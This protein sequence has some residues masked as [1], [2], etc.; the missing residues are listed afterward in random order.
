MPNK[1]KETLVG[2]QPTGDLTK[3]GNPNHNSD[4]Q[5]TSKDEVYTKDD[6]KYLDEDGMDFVSFLFEDYDTG[7]IDY[8]LALKSEEVKNLIKIGKEKDKFAKEAMGEEVELDDNWDEGEFAGLD[9]DFDE[10]FNLDGPISGLESE[11]IYEKIKEI[12]EKFIDE[13]TSNTLSLI[14]KEDKVNGLINNILYDENKIKNATDEEIELLFLSEHLKAKE[15]DILNEELELEKETF[16]NIWKD[17]SV[18][19]KDYLDKMDSI[20]SKK[21]YYENEISKIKDLALD[22]DTKEAYTLN[23][24]QSKLDQLNKFEQLG[25]KY[26]KLRDEYFNLKSYE[27][28]KELSEISEKFRNSDNPYSE[29]R[30]N[31]AIWFNSGSKYE[32]AKN[33]T[34]H[35][36]EETMQHF[37]NMSPE[38]KDVLYTYTTGSRRYNEPL[39]HRNYTAGKEYNEDFVPD[40]VN[41]T[42]AIDKCTWKD[43]VWV[44]RF[45]D[46]NSMFLKT[47]GDFKGKDIYALSDDE[48]QALVGSTIEDTGFFSAGAGKGTGWDG[49]GGTPII[50]NTYCPRGTKMAYLNVHGHFSESPENEMLLQRGYSYRI[51]KV[52]KKMNSYGGYEFYVDM[53]VI[54][55]S[56]ENKFSLEELNKIEKQY[57]KPYKNSWQ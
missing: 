34:K 4:G 42:N 7:E 23:Y 46:K 52:E 21:E 35:F 11:E 57:V 26:E 38:E 43:D 19:V 45:V 56:D 14:D 49:S 37:S 5:F 2:G 36:K 44:Q 15:K 53:E 13:E 41:M 24:L 6:F 31:N 17:Q 9:F 48:L 33:A 22:N 50:L 3:S 29:E 39:R 54:L 18:T 55:G 28:N 30:K 1:E 51:T 32:N 25:Q 47:P 12:K 16:N 27:G 10:E 8:D 40:V 20:P